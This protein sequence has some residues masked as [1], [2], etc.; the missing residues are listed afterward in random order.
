MIGETLGSYKITQKIGAGGQGTVYKAT[1]SK[2]GRTV[3]V[4]VLPAD[5]TAKEANVK[6]FDREARL[7]SSLDHPNICTIFD[8]GEENGL[9][10][11]AMQW[12]E[13]R[14]VRQLVNG[15]PLELESALRIAIQVADALAAAHARGI[16]HRD[17]KSG[18]VMVT[19]AGQVKVLDFGLAKLLDD[20]E[21]QQSG[22]H[23]TE[24]TEVGVPYGTATYAAPEQARGDKVDT[25]ADIFSTGVLL[26]EML[27]GT[28]PFRGKTTVDVRH[29]VI[30]DQPKPLAEARP[31]QSPARLQEILDK[32]MSKDPRD[33]YQKITELRDELRKVL[34]QVSSGAQME[35]AAAPARHLGGSSPASRAMRWL[36]R[37]GG[38]EVQTSV[39]HFTSK[40]ATESPEA[41]FT[42][43]TEPEKKSLA[44]LPF[45]NLNNDPES[46][47]YEF[48][49]AD[50]VITELARIRSLVVRPSSVMSKYQ[51]QAVDPADVGRE[52]NVDAVLSA[53]FIRA[54]ERFRVN[55]QLLD[56][57]TGEIIW[58]DRVDASAADVIAVQDEIT[59]SIVDGLRLELSPDEQAGLAQPRTVNAEAYDEFLRGR[60][61]FARFIFRT[62]AAEDCDAAIRHFSR[63]IELDPDFGLAYDGLGACHVNRVFKGLGGAEDYE[64]AEAAFNKALSIDPK[65]I[66]A[67]MLMVFV[68]LWRG[69]K[70]RA[71][72]EVARMRREAP[73]EAVVHF[74]KATLHRLD[75]EYDR[76][77]RS[78]DRLVHLDP[79]SFV[80]VS[81]NRALIFLYQGKFEEAQKE[82]DRA[83]SVEPN[84]PLLRTFRALTM[85]YTRRVDEA[86]NLLREVLTAHPNLHGVRPFLAM[87][88]S[89][90]G[91][92][93]EARA[94]LNDAVKRNA[95][96]DPDI[97]YAVGSV[98]ALEGDQD[99]AFEWLQRSVALG[100]GNK[101]CFESDPNLKSLR[102]DPR[103]AELMQ[104]I[105]R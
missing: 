49:L 19:D 38:A 102:D 34:Q 27:T 62:V 46:G 93:E 37:M 17:I 44:V 45:K 12:V 53:G 42:T 50:A 98:Y 68:L 10:Y 80:V 51:G 56:V 77:L 43:V 18:N 100:N 22:I 30:Y 36:R 20:N 6:R 29:A 65:I 47:F 85:Y 63:A 83:A 25:R 3:V 99:L 26:Y 101:P 71:R 55:A 96:V 81:Y 24:L 91:K 76:A 86:A 40:P 92:H 60:D 87:C 105:A 15:R 4:K 73:S 21:A 58:S 35:V 90:Q 66:E 32:A 104:K 54:G 13:G 95:S 9:H 11:I 88:L 78:Y 48:S 70:Q 28:W 8:L 84:N 2:L 67:R 82:L 61:R 39:P 16:I 5:L 57:R 97:A 94:E 103:F 75:G 41:S 64:K 14:N 52:L 31:G 33:R 89:R 7:A 59:K 23:R 69:Q 74:V 1:D 72:D 79:A